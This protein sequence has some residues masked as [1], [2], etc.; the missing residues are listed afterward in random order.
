MT[1]QEATHLCIQSDAVEVRRVDNR[2][3]GGR[4][5]FSTR[6]IREGQT[7]ETVPGLL[8]PREQVFA[9]DR[10]QQQASRIS[11]YVFDC[12]FPTKRTYVVLA[13]GYGSIYNHSAT[14]NARVE[15]LE[16]DLLQFIATRDIAPD[17]EILINYLGDGQKKDVGFEVS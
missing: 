4:A 3:K 9:A 7:I 2:G 1:D 16:P 12:P 8:I 5:V 14:P 11:W 15:F 6:N 17:E 10:A 13:L